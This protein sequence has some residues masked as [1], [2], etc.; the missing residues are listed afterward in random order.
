MK[1]VENWLPIS[2]WAGFYEVSD[3]GR[4]R[5]LDRTVL[6]GK[7]VVPLRGKTLKPVVTIWGHMHVGLMRDGHRTKSW[8]HRLVLETFVGP[9]PVSQE[10]CHNNG[11]P[12]DNR[13]SNL[14][15]DTKSANVFDQVRHGVHPSTR[16]THCPM[17]HLL[18]APNLVSAH[19]RRRQ[20]S[21]L[22]CHNAATRKNFIGDRKALAE[23]YYQRYVEK[24]V[25]P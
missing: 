21:C 12:S 17:G 10:A 2:G 1:E 18:V 14:R 23:M 16:K 8:V 22:A 15:W 24:M 11:I 6:I 20:R 19:L 3:M 4:V 7:R 13:V 9:C 25:A 5:S